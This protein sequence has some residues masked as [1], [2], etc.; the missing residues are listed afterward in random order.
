MPRFSAA[1]G[2]VDDAARLEGSA[3]IDADDDAIAVIDPGYAD[4][5]AEGQ[6]PVCGRQILRV[7]YFPGRG[8][9]AFSVERRDA[10]KGVARGGRVGAM[11][12]IGLFADRRRAG[13]GA[14]RRWRR[15]A[16]RSLF[17]PASERTS[18]G[19]GRGRHRGPMAV[20][21]VPYLA[22][23]AVFGQPRSDVSTPA[24]NGQSIDPY[25]NT[26]QKMLRRTHFPPEIP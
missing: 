14:S 22:G 3:V 20:C 25:D 15:M 8:P 9:F 19:A 23:P 2:Q 5:G 7:E 12:P 6:R 21:L 11:K 17:S 1:P 18:N 10:L 13:N 24:E 26:Y 4:A 16:S